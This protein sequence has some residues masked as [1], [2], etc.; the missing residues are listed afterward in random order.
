MLATGRYRYYHMTLR[1]NGTYELRMGSFQN[2]ELGICPPI[3]LAGFLELDLEATFRRSS[4]LFAY[5]RH[6][7]LPQSPSRNGISDS[8]HQRKGTKRD[9]Y[10]SRI[11]VSCPGCKP[12]GELLRKRT[13]SRDSLMATQS[14][15]RLARSPGRIG[16]GRR[17]FGGTKVERPRRAMKLIV[18]V[19]AGH[20]DISLAMKPSQKIV[21]SSLPDEIRSRLIGFC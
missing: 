17:T 3:P 1:V 16:Q 21:I 9:V 4:R 5:V 6:L 14:V 7:E 11:M 12:L 20:L 15:T 2:S 10:S 18:N 13:R 19:G 8:P